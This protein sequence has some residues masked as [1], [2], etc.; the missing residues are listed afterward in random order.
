MSIK[1]LV[2]GASIAGPMAAYWLAKAGARV[3]VV[4]RFPKLR[5]SGQ[6]V[7]IRSCGVTVMRRVPG[8]EKAVRAALVEM[9]GMSF[10]ND[11]GQPIATMKSTGDPDAQSLLSEYEILR[12]DLSKVLVDLAQDNDK[13]DYVFGEQIASM[14]QRD[15]GPVTVQFANGRLPTADYD[16]VVACDGATSRTRAMGF[17]CGPRDHINPVN[18]WAAYVDIQEDLL[19]GSKMGVGYSSPG[20]RV[21]YALGGLPSGGNKLT[22][23]NVLHGAKDE[24][25]TKPFRDAAQQGDKALKAFVADR[26]QDSGWKRHEML[27]AMWKS[28]DFFASEWFQVKLPRLSKG[29]FVV[30]GD[31]GYA[32]GPTGGGT[33]LAMAGAYVLAGEI[34]RH[35]GDL[36]AGLQAYEERMRPIINDLQ[37]IPKGVL[38][39]MAPQTAWG[40]WVRN[41]V[42][43][44]VCWS[45]QFKG[46]FAWASVY[47]ASSFGGG[48]QY[49]LPVYEWDQ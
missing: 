31:A 4:E 3:T 9:E 13:I 12:G 2:S 5:T 34:G 18:V 15:S 24:D 20:G 49:A 6:N 32:A 28:D 14:Q 47:F 30:V 42:F 45:M 40:I 19:S 33:S 36:A 44:F 29:N 27:E 39:L 10:V 7:D 8:M 38:T 41:Q 16:L 26:F 11:K 1:V 37:Q 23:M 17:G 46:L 43:R 35:K 22:F 48:D 21:C 25:V